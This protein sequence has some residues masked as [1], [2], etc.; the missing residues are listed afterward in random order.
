[1]FTKDNL[2]DLISNLFYYYRRT[3]GPRHGVR[4]LMYHSIGTL[5]ENRFDNLFTVDELIFRSQIDFMANNNLFE[6]VKLN[7]SIMDY[8]E[9]KLKIAITFDDGFADNLYVAA[10]ILLE[11]SIPF[12]VFITSDFIEKKYY[13]NKSEVIELSKLPN[14]TIGSHGKTHK[15][16]NFMKNEELRYEL[17]HSKNTIEDITGK[18]VNSISFPSGQYNKDVIDISKEVGYEIGATSKFNINRNIANPLELARNVIM[19]SDD[20]AIFTQ[21]LYGAWDWYKI[22]DL[23]RRIKNIYVK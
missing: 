21:K 19:G 8:G 16:L 9:S 6:F 22:W 11:H 20:D 12:T 3:V 23:Y 1:L 10:P 2:K 17:M 4:I 14:V 15:P 18:Q 13:L 5:L 7:K